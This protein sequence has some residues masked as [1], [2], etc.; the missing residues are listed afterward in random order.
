MR[1][2][3]AYEQGIGERAFYDAQARR[4]APELHG[5]PVPDAG[6]SMRREVEGTPVAEVGTERQEVLCELDGRERGW[7]GMRYA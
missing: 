5:R 6:S 2:L 3:V 7:R 4:N 1:E